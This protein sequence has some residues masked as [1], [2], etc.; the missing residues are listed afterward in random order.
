MEQTVTY[1]KSLS[2]EAVAICKGVR[3]SA[4]PESQPEPCW[5]TSASLLLLRS[6]DGTVTFQGAAT[7][8]PTGSLLPSLLPGAVSPD[9]GW[10]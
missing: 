9:L 6:L 1:P 4:S 2:R 7:L 10:R 5:L 8:S 3:P